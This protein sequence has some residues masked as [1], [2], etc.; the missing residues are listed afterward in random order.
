MESYKAYENRFARAMKEAIASVP[1][2]NPLMH[3]LDNE[4]FDLYS[5]KNLSLVDELSLL[6]CIY[7]R[8]VGAYT[9]IKMTIDSYDELNYLHKFATCM[10]EQLSSEFP[11]SDQDW[12]EIRRVAD[13]VLLHGGN[14]G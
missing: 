9:T 6:D 2:Y 13:M 8:N 12:K 14:L 4:N 5:T 3:L 10:I 7:N 11:K 1:S